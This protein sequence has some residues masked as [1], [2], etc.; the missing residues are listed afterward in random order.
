MLKAHPDLAGKLFASNNLTKASTS[1]QESAGLDKLSEKELAIFSNLNKKY[2]EKHRFPFIVAVR[3]Y[4][5]NGILSSF[6]DRLENE[7]ELEFDEA[8]S[9]VERIAYIRLQDILP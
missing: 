1:E 3:D 9:Q 5:K 8:C 2:F 6:R 7:T 4:D